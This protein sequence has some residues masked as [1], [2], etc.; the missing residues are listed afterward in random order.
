MVAFAAGRLNAPKLVSLWGIP[1]LRAIEINAESVAIGA[2]AT[3]LDLRR[4]AVI[5]AELPLARQSR[6]LDRLHRQPE[7]RNARR[8]SC[9]RF[10]G[11]GFLARA[12]GLRR[13]DRADLRARPPPHSLLANFTPATNATFSPPMNCSTRFTCRGD[14]RATSNIC[15]KWE[16][17][18]PWPLPRSRWARRRCLRKAWSARFASERRAW[19]RSPRA[20]CKPKR[21][22]SAKPVTRETVQAARR[23]LLAEVKPIDDIRSTA[24]YRRRVA[25]NLTRRVSA[26]IA[27]GGI[28]RHEC[29]ACS[30]ERGRRI[31]G[32]GRDARLLRIEAL[33]CGDGGAAPHRQRGSN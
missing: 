19:R 5:A 12:A 13:G 28:A 3:F 1:D 33:G 20:F 4:H 17:G 31:R 14:S 16:R 9:Q 15:A 2:A 10:A 7:P 21:R 25:A 18:A 23:A 27:P 29:D 32:P 22:C 30:V 6:K 11:R 8:Q 26:R 24:E